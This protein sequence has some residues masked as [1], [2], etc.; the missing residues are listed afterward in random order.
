MTSSMSS[1]R[2][3]VFPSLAVKAAE[4]RICVR[5]IMDTTDPEIVFDATGVCNHCHRYQSV[6]ATDTLQ[7]SE[8]REALEAI[9]GRIRADGK[10]KKYDCIIGLSGGV[11]SSY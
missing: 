9:A 8:G 6:V 3:G 7:G 1:L 10:G 5:C 11:D 2:R 4:Y